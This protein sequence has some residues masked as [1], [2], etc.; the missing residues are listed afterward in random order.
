[1]AS[2]LHAIATALMV[3]GDRPDRF[4][5]AHQRCGHAMV[6]DLEDAVPPEGKA[7]ARAQVADY[8]AAGASR[9]GPLV[10]VRI[11]ALTDANALDDLTSL[12][13]RADALDFVAVPMVES[14]RDVQIVRAALGTSDL[15]VMAIIETIAGLDGARSI[16]AALDGEGAIGFGAADY[17]AAAGMAMTRDALLPARIRLVEA[18]AQGGVPCFDVPYLQIGDDAGLAAEAA[19]V[20]DLG[21]AGKLAIHPSQVQPIIEAFQPSADAVAQAD[22]VIEAFEQAGRVAIQ[23][24]GRMIDKPVYD[25]AL[26]VRARSGQAH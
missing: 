7:A 26:A 2:S 3:P 17:S 6:I 10:G 4:D 25:Q 20:R 19:Y 23:V 14:G 12:R 24:D 22:R 18:G 1:M 8:L 9:A 5:K 15:P 21:F 16:A 13:D 11:N